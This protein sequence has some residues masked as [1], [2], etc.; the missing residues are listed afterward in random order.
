MATQ[1]GMATQL[2]L[3]TMPLG[4][5][6][7]AVELTSGTTSGTSGSMR[8]AEELSTTMAPA[9]AATGLNSR[10]IEDGV[11]ERTKSTPAN[12]SGRIAST[13][14]VWPRNVMDLPALFGEARNLID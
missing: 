4:M 11:L 12:A 7:K 10:L 1:S 8:Q 5:F 9:L 2:G 3:A 6:F 13:A 14:W